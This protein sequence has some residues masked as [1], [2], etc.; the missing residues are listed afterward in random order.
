M[1]KWRDN[2]WTEVG[3][4]TSQNY[5]NPTI[6]KTLFPMFWP[7]KAFDLDFQSCSLDRRLKL[8]PCMLWPGVA[9]KD[10][11]NDLNVF[12]GVR[13]RRRRGKY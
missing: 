4:L 2:T 6:F 13:R 11:N 12:L 7:P 10:E 5:K 9:K 8:C 3:N 1:P